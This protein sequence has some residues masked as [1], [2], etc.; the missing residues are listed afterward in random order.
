[1]V[2]LGEESN[3]GRTHRVLFGQEELE[4]EMTACVNVKTR[5]RKTISRSDKDEIERSATS[6]AN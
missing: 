5:E 1:M 4:L 2:D 6:R 3:L